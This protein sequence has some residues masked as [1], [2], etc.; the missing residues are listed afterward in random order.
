[1]FVVHYAFRISELEAWNSSLLLWMT[2]F[3]VPRAMEELI[4]L[5]IW[6]LVRQLRSNC[7]RD[8]LQGG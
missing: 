5:I 6:D 7:N 8:H 3:S 2:W 4:L 1:M